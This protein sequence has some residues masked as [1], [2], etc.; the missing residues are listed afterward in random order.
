[1]LSCGWFVLETAN[2]P[3]SVLLAGFAPDGPTSGRNIR[4]FV[5]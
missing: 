3:I 1:L 4:L 5:V 2:S